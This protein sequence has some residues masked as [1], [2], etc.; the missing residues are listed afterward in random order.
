LSHDP[1]GQYSRPSDCIV[2][3]YKIVP[4]KIADELATKIICDENGVYVLFARSMNI[5]F[6]SGH[7]TRKIKSIH[8]IFYHI[9]GLSFYFSVVLYVYVFVRNKA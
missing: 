8:A 1:V 6:N 9:L 2:A 5:I 4:I 3:H 7:T